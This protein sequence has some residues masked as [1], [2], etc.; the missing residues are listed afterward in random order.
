[1]KCD[2]TRTGLLILLVSVMEIYL[3][4]ECNCPED[5]CEMFCDPIH[6]INRLQGEVVSKSCDKCKSGTW[7]HNG[8]CLRCKHLGL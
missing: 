5:F 8:F 6:C 7:H 1:M 4:T 2:I 3:D